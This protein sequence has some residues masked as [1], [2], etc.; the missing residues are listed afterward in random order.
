M[1]SGCCCIADDARG[2]DQGVSG[3]EGKAPRKS[4]AYPGAPD[5][6]EQLAFGFRAPRPVTIS[7]RNRIPRA[8]PFGNP[9]LYLSAP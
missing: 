6:V 5:M 4:E 1:G 8:D 2:A 3:R 7:E 9:G